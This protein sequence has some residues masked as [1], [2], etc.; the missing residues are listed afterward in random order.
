ML[1]PKFNSGNLALDSML[2]PAKYA[3]C[4]NYNVHLHFKKNNKVK[5]MAIMSLSV[6]NTYTHIHV[7]KLIDISGKIPSN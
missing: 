6:L 7:S 4:E 5:N 1:K 2:I 3:A